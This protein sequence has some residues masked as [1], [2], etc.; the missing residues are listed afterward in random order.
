MKNTTFCFRKIKTTSG[1]CWDVHSMINY[2]DSLWFP[3]FSRWIVTILWNIT[4]R[5]NTETTVH[6]I[7]SKFSDSVW[8][9][10]GTSQVNVLCKIICHNICVVIREMHELGIQPD[11]NFCAKSSESVYK[12]EGWSHYSPQP[13]QRPH[14]P[15]IRLAPL[16]K[17]A[18]R[19]P[20][21]AR[22]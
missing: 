5:I 17:P 6:M 3:P 9:K 10:T 11:F 20:W 18:A 12:V 2:P 21:H 1:S 4:T 22:S 16:M 19:V 13:F 8:S 14:N 15:R 7:K